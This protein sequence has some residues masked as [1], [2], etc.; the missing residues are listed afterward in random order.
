MLKAR[1]CS[2]I[3][4]G[5]VCLTLAGC[6]KTPD[7]L[8]SGQTSIE[9]AT[10]DDG[11]QEI[12]SE[13]IA[14]ESFMNIIVTEVG[15][16]SANC[17]FI[18]NEKTGG[19]IIVDPGYNS[20]RLKKLCEENDLQPEA[21][22]LTHGHSDHIE[23]ASTMRNAFDI[24]V[25]AWFEEEVIFGTNNVKK[26]ITWLTEEDEL[27]IAGFSIKVIH[28]P[29]HTIGSVCYYIEKENVLFSGDTM[30]R[31]TYGRTDMETGDFSAIMDSFENKLYTL[32]D[33]TLVYPGHGADTTIAYEK[34]NNFI[35]YSIS[36]MN[37]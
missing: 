5:S 21:I 3:V 35:N 29:G 19:I 6:A 37:Q 20:S 4:A 2:L 9:D 30:F 16:L 31:D 25:Y 34:E 8:D 12:E 7:A 23:A 36:A 26:N 1:L 15:D 33:E 32:P 17:Y 24:P 18:C 11:G 27:E 28:T 10:P 13:E 22:L 14:E